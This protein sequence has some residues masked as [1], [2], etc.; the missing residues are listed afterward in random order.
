MSTSI[1]TQEMINLAAAGAPDTDGLKFVLAED[2]NSPDGG[3]FT[4]LPGIGGV[5]LPATPADTPYTTDI[6]SIEYSGASDFPQYYQQ[7]VRGP[8]RRRRLHR[9]ASLPTD[10]LAGVFRPLDELADAVAENPLSRRDVA[11]P[12]TS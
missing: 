6:Y 2:L 10:R 1:Q 3:F 11:T 4:R 12:T 7:H 8:Q 5:N 9:P